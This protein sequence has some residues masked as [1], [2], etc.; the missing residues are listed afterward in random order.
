MSYS[1]LPMLSSKNFIVSGLTFRSLIHLDFI[2][3]YSVRKRSN[4]IHFNKVIQ[5]FHTT[6]QRHYFFQLYV[7]VSFVKDKVPIFLQV[8]LW[9]FYLVPLAYTSVFLPVTYCL[10][11]CSFVVWSEI[12]H[13]DSSSSVLSQD[14]FVYS[15]CFLFTYEL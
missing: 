3:G 8:Y 6:C 7:L 12:M 1:V 13:V 5:I 2:F 4:F 11:D 10:G 14:C 15:G 9:T